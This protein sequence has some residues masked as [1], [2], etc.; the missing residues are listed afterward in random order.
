MPVPATLG[1]GGATT[2]KSGFVD[3]REVAGLD[4]RDP[5]GRG[6]EMGSDALMPRPSFA[7]RHEDEQM[8]H[9]G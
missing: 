4:D 6:F 2:F 8:P 5:A 7:P 3:G 1:R 9:V